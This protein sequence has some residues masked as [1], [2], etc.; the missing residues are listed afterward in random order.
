MFR[1]IK[2]FSVLLKMFSVQS[3]LTYV[4]GTQKNAL[5]E[6]VLLSTHSKCF[7]REIRKLFF[8]YIFSA[9]GM[10]VMP[11]RVAQWVKCLQMHV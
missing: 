7:G 3:Y 1:S 9:I 8:L 11:G 6:M 10:Y 4:L 5:V 2:N